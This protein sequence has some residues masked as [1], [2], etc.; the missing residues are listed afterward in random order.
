MGTFLNHVRRGKIRQPTQ[1][2]FTPEVWR[3]GYE[4]IAEHDKADIDL[5]NAAPI[6]DRIFTDL[7]NELSKGRFQYSR[8]RDRL[9]AICAFINHEV[10]AL[11]RKRP[12]QQSP[13]E[14]SAP[15]LV[16]DL[17]NL[18][19][20]LRSGVQITPDDVLSTVI[21][22]AVLPLD[23]A[24]QATDDSTP[25]ATD[26]MTD[27]GL[28]FMVA[29][30]YCVAVALWSSCL[31]TE[32]LVEQGP[33]RIVI[34]AR[35]SHEA[36]RA[37]I[38][39][40]RYQNYL[41]QFTNNSV[42]I[43]RHELSIVEKKAI[44]VSKGVTEFD[45]RLR[46]NPFVVGKLDLHRK[47]NVPFGVVNWI[48][49]NE[50]YLQPFMRLPLPKSKELTVE[51]LYKT[52]EVL[53]SLVRAVLARVP[54]SPGDRNWFLAH[55]VRATRDQ[56]GHVLVQSLSL[57]PVVIDAAI[58]FLSYQRRSE[59]LWQ[60]PLIALNDDEFLI[61]SGPL[62]YGNMLRTAERWLRHDGFDLD[63]RGPIFEK[64]AR[65]RVAEFLQG[66]SL[67]ADA[68]VARGRVLAGPDREEIDLLVRI[69]Q[70]LLVGELKCQFFPADAI[71]RHRFC[72]RL[73]QGAA[74]A[75]RKAEVVRSYPE[76][77]QAAIG[78]CD[79]EKIRVIPLVLSNCVWGSGYPVDDVAVAD[80]LYLRTLFRDGGLRT[81]VVMKGSHEEDP[82]SFI[83]Y[84]NDQAEAER[85]IP[86]LLLRQPVVQVFE[87]LVQKRGRPMP[88][89]LNGTE[90]IE[91]YY[92]VSTDSRPLDL[93][94]PDLHGIR[95]S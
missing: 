33:G 58:Q 81:M 55:A 18:T 49:A 87:G 2:G 32:T 77:V 76:D 5:F 52:W 7:R 78:L 79:T 37:A 64:L 54:G 35:D 84:Y 8:R 88:I 48:I 72:E 45:P 20:T 93:D 30:L 26:T 91:E 62:L 23:E 63:K 41:W 51:I 59:G 17:I 31:W 75:K 38:S 86:D 43:W 50:D 19:V 95:G 36:R 61:A 66:S 27:M 10:A 83:R 42:R 53:G 40:H 70:L 9:I 94:V 24:L 4:A 28:A 21:D 60:K 22:A 82:G 3:Q 85:R 14:K 13:A 12:R 69:G 74:Q 1:I 73:R 57:D 68:S 44:T 29:N 16:S 92:T 39:D 46:R 89:A 67:L 56:I 90:I 65:E 6:F 34:R 80:L 11:E 25:L 71:E 47:R 15:V